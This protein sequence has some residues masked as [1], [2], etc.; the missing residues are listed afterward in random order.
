MD[1]FTKV[2]KGNE[3]LLVKLDRYLDDSP[4]NWGIVV[5]VA[6]VITVL[7]IITMLIKW[8]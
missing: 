8:V 1:V 5:K 6:A 2:N 4:A 7:S 3:S